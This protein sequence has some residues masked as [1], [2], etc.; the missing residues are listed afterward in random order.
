MSQPTPP[1]G[2]PQTAAPASLADVGH[3]ALAQV[4]SLLRENEALSQELCSSYEQIHALIDFTTQIDSVAAPGDITRI[5]AARIATLLGAPRVVLAGASGAWTAYDVSRTG[6]RTVGEYAPTPDIESLVADARRADRSEV[7][8][9]FCAS[10]RAL[11]C[12]LVRLDGVMDFICVKR[13]QTAPDFTSADVRLCET[14]LAFGGQI[15]RNTELHDRIRRTSMETTRALVSAIDQKDRYTS[16]H[17]ERVGLLARRLAAELKLSNEQIEQLEWAGLLHDVGKI[18]VPEEILNKPGRLTD[19]EFAV[20][21]RHPEMGYEILQHIKSFRSILD[22]VLYHHE[23]P[24]GGGYPRGLRGDQIP[25]AAAIIHVVDVF[26]ALTSQRSY[27]GQFPVSRGIEIMRA[28]AGTKLDA[29]L[30]E[31]FIRVL[32]R[33]RAEE[34]Q[35]IAQYFAH[36]DGEIPQ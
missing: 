29:E 32:R 30:V 16:G 23:Q 25:I 28:E 20:V 7:A 3:A 33:M 14:L 6:A 34:P 2:A 1:S 17:S 4:E 24:D 27:R 36:L 21:R 15:L 22:G 11:L 12:P 10:G 18:G 13:P 8:V 35:L 26:D 19:E 5:L 9:H 31:S